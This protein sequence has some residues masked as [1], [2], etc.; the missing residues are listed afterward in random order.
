M[1]SLKEGGKQMGM[2]W[3]FGYSQYLDF[4]SSPF[5]LSHPSRVY[6]GIGDLLCHLHLR[7]FVIKLT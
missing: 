4:H 6:A 7:V 3:G 2:F 5:Q 1:L